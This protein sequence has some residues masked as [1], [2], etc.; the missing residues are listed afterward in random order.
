MV[1]V[2][3]SFKYDLTPRVGRM[4]EQ[5]KKRGAHNTQNTQAQVWLGKKYIFDLQLCIWTQN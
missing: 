5:A 3:F 4:I 2:Y 1:D